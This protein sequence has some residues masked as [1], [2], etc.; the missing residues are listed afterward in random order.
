MWTI[1]P[2]AARLS[3][4]GEIRASNLSPIVVHLLGYQDPYADQVFSTSL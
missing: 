2:D 4:E 3:I 1:E